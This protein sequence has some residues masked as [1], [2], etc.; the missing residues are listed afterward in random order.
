MYSL[1]VK[2]KFDAAHYLPDYD[3]DCARLHGHSWKVDM[4]VR[5]SEIQTNGMGIDF[6]ELK[7]IIKPS[8]PDHENLNDYFDFVPTAENIAKFLYDEIA[9]RLSVYCV[10][11]D[12]KISLISVTVWESDT[13]GV[14]YHE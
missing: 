14:K 8:L 9:F 5:F 6:K 10:P 2:D 11:V 13:A 4:E 7:D 12:E 1:I 3:G